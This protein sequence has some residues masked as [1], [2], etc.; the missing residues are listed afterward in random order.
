MMALA[1]LAHPIASC[2]QEA[3]TKN[4]EAGLIYHIGEKGVMPPKPI[5]TPEP[6]YDDAGRRAKLS[7]TVLLSVIVT[8]D[9]QT[10]DVTVEKSLSP[11]LDKKSIE[12]V[13]RWKFKPAMKDGEPVAVRLKVETSFRIR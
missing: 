9:G 4:P 1:L 13:S 10:R 7:G 12:A 11:G 3:T 5:Y 2:A 6:E 8:K